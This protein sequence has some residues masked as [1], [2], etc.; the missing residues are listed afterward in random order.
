MS[1]KQIFSSIIVALILLSTLVIPITPIVQATLVYSQITDAITKGK[2]YLDRFYVDNFPSAG[3]AVMRDL[4]S[5]PFNIYSSYA[6]EF[7]YVGTDNVI[8]MNYKL[9]DGISESEMKYFFEDGYDKD[10]NDLI[11]YVKYKSLNETHMQLTVKK[12]SSDA[13]YPIHL[14]IGSQLIAYNINSAPDNTEWVLVQKY[15]WVSARYVARHA[16]RIAAWLYEDFGETEKAQKLHNFMDYYGYTK[17]VYAPVWGKSNNYNDDELY[18][19]TTFPDPTTWQNLPWKTNDYGEIPYKSRLAYAPARNLYLIINNNSTKPPALHDLLLALHYMNKYGYNAVPYATAL[20][21][22]AGWDGNGFSRDATFQGISYKAPAYQEYAT[23]VGLVA[24]IKYYHLTG[25]TTVLPII[26]N[27]A[28]VLLQLQYK[29]GK[30]KV[31][32]LNVTYYADHNGGFLTSYK[33]GGS[34]IWA[35]WQ[36]PWIDLVYSLLE[37]FG[38]YD[39]M[40]PEYPFLSITNTESTILALKALM[41]YSKLNRAPPIGSSIDNDLA[42]TKFSNYFYSVQGDPAIVKY[43]VKDLRDGTKWFFI[44]NGNISISTIKNITVQN[45]LSNPYLKLALQEYNTTYYVVKGPNR[46]TYADLIVS[47]HTSNGTVLGRVQRQLHNVTST[48]SQ[49]RK[50]FNS[51]HEIAFQIP[52]TLTPGNYYV[53]I[54]IFAYARYGK[55][56]WC[57]EYKNGTAYGKIVYLLLEP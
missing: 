55:I 52:Y 17:D 40:P 18:S 37:I 19:T 33:P 51:T 14:Y 6:G 34:Y 25:D 47:L 41:E 36:S 21:Q 1:Y 32:G 8:G 49:V 31:D 30:T 4:P 16:T 44:M 38:Y 3:Y 39:S 50:N 24:Y 56:I 29:Y 43:Y 2:A 22:R 9:G 20:L 57:S 7:R 46:I 11:I 5:L 26:D 54:T 53:N 23:A 12:I 28:N 15:G 45:E 10:Y 42:Q 13:S 27:I 35:T 48:P